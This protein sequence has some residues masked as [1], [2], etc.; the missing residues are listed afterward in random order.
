M[1]IMSLRQG[2]SIDID[3]VLNDTKMGINCLNDLLGVKR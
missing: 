1:T 2:E 3:M